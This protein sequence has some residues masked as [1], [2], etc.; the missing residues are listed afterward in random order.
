MTLTIGEKAYVEFEGYEFQV[1]LCHRQG[2]YSLSVYA[3]V[4]HN[5]ENP[6]VAMTQGEYVTLLASS[7]RSKA[8]DAAA[9]ELADK[10]QPALIAKVAARK[11]GEQFATGNGHG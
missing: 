4:G 9:L 10:Q 7:R 8:K 5:G 6:V 3:V 1:Y 2:Q 11:L